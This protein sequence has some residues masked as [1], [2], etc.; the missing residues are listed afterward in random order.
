MESGTI[1][2]HKKAM[3]SSVL[4]T[5]LYW[6]VNHEP[7]LLLISGDS[8]VLLSLFDDYFLMVIIYVCHKLNYCT[9]NPLGCPQ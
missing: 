4:S 2:P 8:A 1:R 3:R 5:H 6:S 9:P 7:K